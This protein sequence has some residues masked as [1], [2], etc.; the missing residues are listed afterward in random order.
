MKIGIADYQA[1]NLGSLSSALGEIKVDHFISSNS[2]DLEMADLI[3]LPGVGSFAAG[4]QNLKETGLAETI[5]EHA[6]KGKPVLGICLGMHLLASLGFEGGSTAGL[7]LIPG[8]VLRLNPSI[9]YRIPHMGW[10][11]VHYKEH[12]SFVY[13]AHSYYF[14]PSSNSEVEIRS[15]YELGG[16]RYPAHIQLGNVAGIQFHP[17]KSGPNGLNILVNSIDTLAGNH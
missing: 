8:E 4:I 13:F 11:I 5:C 1:S 15:E 7:N 12:T 9:D 6:Q 17:E 2:K 14:Q 10:D 16:Q 3:L